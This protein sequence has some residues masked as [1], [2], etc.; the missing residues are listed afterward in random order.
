MITKG[1]RESAHFGE[2]VRTAY[3][4]AGM[5]FDVDYVLVDRAVFLLTEA[6]KAKYRPDALIKMAELESI[7]VWVLESAL[8]RSAVNVPAWA[9]VMTC[10]ELAQRLLSTKALVF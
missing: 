9:R 7:S 5:Q 4:F 2:S 3:M 10:A 1:A 6:P 8:K